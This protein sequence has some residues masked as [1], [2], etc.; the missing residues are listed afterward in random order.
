IAP[1]LDAGAGV[2]V[3]WS[4]Q[5]TVDLAL[6]ARR[7]AEDAET[8]FVLVSDGGGPVTDVPGEKVATRFLGSP[9]QGARAASPVDGKRA[10]RGFAARV[11]FALSAAMRELGELTGRAL[12]PLE[13]YH[14]ADA[15]EIVVAFGQAYVAARA[16]AEAL[17]REGRRVGAVGVRSLRPFYPAELVK[18]VARARAVAVIEPLD[19]ALAPA[20]PVATAL[21]A[22]FA[23]AITWAPGFPGVGHIPPVVSV[24]FATVTGAV[25]EHEV[26]EAL[27]ELHAGD[28]ARRLLVFGSDTAV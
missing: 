1:A 14:T 5:E 21:K 17:R 25:S 11:P 3:A 10:E 8:P 6:A 7:A 20:G 16:T 23:D 15:E 13:R 2:I 4:A 28:R 26:R 9:P 22:A 24:A 19:V 27:G 12:A 18:A